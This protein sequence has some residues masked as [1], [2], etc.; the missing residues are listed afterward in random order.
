MLEEASLLWHCPSCAPSIKTSLIENG[1]AA[2]LVN[3]VD[4]EDTSFLAVL[5]EKLKNEVKN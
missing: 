1:N 3:I 2:V 5:F 4:E